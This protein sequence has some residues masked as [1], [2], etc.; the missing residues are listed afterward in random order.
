MQQLADARSNASAG[1]ADISLKNELEECKRQLEMAAQ[2]IASLE[3]ELE[4]K[5]LCCSELCISLEKEQKRAEE[6]SLQLNKVKLQAEGQYKQMRVEHR[7]RQRAQA[8][9][10]VL[11]EQIKLLKSADRQR[12]QDYENSSSKA[13][14]SLLK[15]EKEKSKLQSEL[16]KCL[17]RSQAEFRNSKQQL[18]ALQTKLTESRRLAS[19]LKKQCGR[20]AKRR[21][22]AV[23]K[24]REQVQKK[25]TTHHL[26]SKGVYTE[27][28]RNLIRLLVKAGCSRGYVGQ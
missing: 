10:G 3:S 25:Y 9:K 7:A 4:A 24:A 13:I 26:L 1:R 5:S 15:V 14:D 12:S 19:N 11:L 8:R 20:A 27:G 28:T 2:K 22:H 23:A 16:S 17:E 6:L 21:D 18:H